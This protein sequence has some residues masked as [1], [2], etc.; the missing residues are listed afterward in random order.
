MKK[1]FLNTIVFLLIPASVSATG[2]GLSV[3]ES[4]GGQLGGVGLTDIRG[5]PVNSAVAGFL[6]DW[7][8]FFDLGQVENSP[9]QGGKKKV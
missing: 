1:V 3:P 9:C 5:L 6:P 8:F 4:A 7:T 2:T